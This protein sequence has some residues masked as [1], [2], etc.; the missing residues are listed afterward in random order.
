MKSLKFWIVIA[1]LWIALLSWLD[2]PEVDRIRERNQNIPL[3]P[4]SP[5]AASREIIQGA[6]G[7]SDLL[8]DAIFLV[9]LAS[10]VVFLISKFLGGSASEPKAEM[11]DNT[12]KFIAM[13][14]GIIIIA[15][16]LG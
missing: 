9:A 1:V 2:S 4:G 5:A 11:D 6:T 12:A 14:I 15:V 13:M 8:S 3:R 10:G 16:L 7:A